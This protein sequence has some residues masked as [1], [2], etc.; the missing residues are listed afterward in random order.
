MR[1]V[2]DSLEEV[3]SGGSYESKPVEA[4]KERIMMKLHGGM[5]WSMTDLARAPE[6]RKIH[7]KHV[8]AAAKALVREKKVVLDGGE[9]RLAMPLHGD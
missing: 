3:V 8:E 9:I 7:F 6:F 1:G 5:S 4:A 2:L